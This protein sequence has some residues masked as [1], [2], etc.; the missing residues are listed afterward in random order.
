MYKH[1][2]FRV[3][4]TTYDM[5]REQ[6]SVNIRTHPYIMVLAHEDEGEEDERHPYWYAKVLGIFHVNIRVS[7]DIEVERMDFLWVHWFG[8]D[9]DHSSGFEK[10]RLHR[11]GLLDPATPTSFGFLNPSDVLRAVHLIP[12]FS[13]GKTPALDSETDNAEWEF[14]YVSM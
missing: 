14:F 6:D 7:G 8:R 11:I 4:Y 10:H 2:V 12:A 13:V 9:P 3:N 1:E 5:R